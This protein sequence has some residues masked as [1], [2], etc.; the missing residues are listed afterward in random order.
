MA[1]RLGLD[2][3]LNELRYRKWTMHFFGK[4]KMRPKLIAA[5]WRWP[6]DAGCA[7]VLVLY[8]EDRATGYR[9]LTPD[10]ADPLL[11]THVLWV[12][13]GPALWTL[14][15][16]LTIEP[17]GQIGAS[18]QLMPAPPACL[19]PPHLHRPKTIRPPMSH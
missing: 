1:A 3:A 15:A 10:G 9:A 2:D 18:N 13:S 8:S 6:E 11:P 19:I 12:Y 7:D 4:D 14:R 17:P 16:V 5:V